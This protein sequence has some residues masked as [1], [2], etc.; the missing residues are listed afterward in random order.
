MTVQSLLTA[1]LRARIVLG[2]DGDRLTYEAP[3]GALTADL[4]TALAAR[5]P[6]LLQV[7]PRLAGMRQHTAPIPTAQSAQ[8]APGGPGRCFSCGDGLDHPAAYGRCTWCSIAVEAFYQ[9]HGEL[10]DAIVF[11]PGH[12]QER[13]A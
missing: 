11:G 12:R 3:P 5:K 9:E 8:E 10:S 7:V 1:C 2:V 6:E 13:T 4:R